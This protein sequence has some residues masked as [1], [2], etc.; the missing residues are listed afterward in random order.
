MRPR[1]HWARVGLTAT[2]QRRSILNFRITLVHSAS[3]K[4]NFSKSTHR[5]SNHLRRRSFNCNQNRNGL[6]NRNFLVEILITTQYRFVDLG[7]CPAIASRF[8]LCTS[9]CETAILKRAIPFATNIPSDVA[10]NATSH[11][12]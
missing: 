7:Q 3:A 6:C 4:P 11:C 8:W 2:Q 1:G 9:R 12:S 10:N 5:C